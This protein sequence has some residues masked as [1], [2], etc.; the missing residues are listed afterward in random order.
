MYKFFDSIEDSFIDIYSGY[1]L[2][3]EQL[4]RA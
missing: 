3:V 1:Y 2:L 4:V